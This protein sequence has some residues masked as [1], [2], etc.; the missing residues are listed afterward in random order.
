MA[1]HRGQFWAQFGLSSALMII[2][3]SYIVNS[4]KKM[5][6]DDAKLYRPLVSR[7]DAQKKQDDLDVFSN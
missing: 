7:E 1:Y 6:A 3:P 4:T 5:Y 2:K